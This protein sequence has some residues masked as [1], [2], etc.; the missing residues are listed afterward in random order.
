MKAT[1]ISLLI[2]VVF[3][4]TGV[5]CNRQSKNNLATIDVTQNY[6]EKEVLLSE[7]ANFTYLLINSEKDEYLFTG[8]PRALGK[9]TVVV[10]DISSGSLLFFS[11]DGNPKSRFNRKGNGPEEY[12]SANQI[13]YDEENDDVFVADRNIIQVYSSTGEHKRKITL[14]AE[15]FINGIVSFDEHSLLLY[16]GSVETRTD[17]I[18]HLAAPFVCISKTD[19]KVL[20]NIDLPT[21]KTRLGLYREMDNTKFFVAGFASRLIESEDGALL[22]N[23]EAD[24]V[25]LYSK[26]RTLIPILNQTP[27]VST[28][29]P[30]IYL[31]NVVDVGRYQ[32]M[33]VYT[34]R[35]EMRARPYPVTYLMRDKKTNEICRQKIILPDYQ[36]KSFF[37]SPRQT[38]RD[39]EHGAFFELDVIELKQAYDENKLSG[40]LKELVSGLD[41]NT[42][43]NIFVLFQFKQ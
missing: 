13:A 6:L 9:N 37:I 5:S 25:F 38:G 16:D 15:T 23:P 11:K 32:F 26:D 29:D 18:D 10:P 31:N 14:P 1:L 19:G 30:I 8:K 21:G 36:E 20:D 7:V 34:V 35:L 22:C 3:F 42:S 17:R 28:L 12:L 40:K 27:S 41:E 4:T 43:N 2:V 33:E 39:Y 24:T